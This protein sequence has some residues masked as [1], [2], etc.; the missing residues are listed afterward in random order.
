[1]TAPLRPLER[2]PVLAVALGALALT[3][4]LLPPTPGMGDSAEL[5]LALALAGIPHP[6]G[7]P[8]YVLG[9]HPFVRAAHALGASWVLA[10]NLWS[11]LG[12]A[13]AAGAYA[14][15]VQHVV[16][17]LEDE[18]ALAGGAPMPGFARWIAVAFPP[19]LLVLNPVWLDSATIAEVYS[20]NNAWIAASAAF[21]LGRLRALDGAARRGEAGP[22]GTGDLPAALC[23]GLLCGL[24][25]A[26][27][28]TSLFFVLPLTVALVAAQV[29]CGR[30]RASL[31]FAG[32]GGALVPLASYGWIPWRAAH[33]A[34]FQWPVGPSATALWLHARGA[35][36]AYYVGRF[37]PNAE[38]WALIRRGVLPW[39]LPGMLL[40]SLVA[41]RST[42]RALRRGLL[43]L[44]FG[45]AMQVAFIV[46]YGVPDPEFYFLPA[47]MSGLL[48][49]APGL[50]WLSRRTSPALACLIAAGLALG[51]AAWSVPR[52]LAE[53]AR[54]AEVD[55]GFRAAWR[56]IPFERGIVLW[57][58]DHY[59]RFKALQLLE[60]QRPGLFVDSPDMLIW[61]SR[62]RAFQR[63]FGFDPLAGLTLRTP[64]DVAQVAE[65]IRRHASVPV[66]VLP[67]YRE[68]GAEGRK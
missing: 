46:S 45:A 4:L 56:S 47:L 24:C 13:V 37:A 18:R 54:L 43:A 35:A 16:A 10:A 2:G 30:W 6:T 14:R 41:L 50:S 31:A 55:A 9:G 48:V 34:A 33:P 22:A 62:R 38:Q 58:D 17:A 15:L 25:G 52:A 28:V 63:R 23:W 51:L 11:A 20:W 19:A 3:A 26:H 53:R 39:L 66:L 59:Q 42:S 68:P 57:R 32:L 8:I 27:H 64:D 5:V 65:N 21:A 61:P 36:Y 40:G 60:G 7:Y 29:S 12:A 44:M 67:E 1:M 49:G